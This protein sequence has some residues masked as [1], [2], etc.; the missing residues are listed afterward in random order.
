[1]R[2]AALLRIIFQINLLAPLLCYQLQPNP[3]TEK[4][5]SEDCGPAQGEYL[6]RAQRR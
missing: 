4:K 2:L 1:M 3:A 6:L 5:M